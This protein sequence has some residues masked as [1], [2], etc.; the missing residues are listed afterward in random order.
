MLGTEDREKAMNNQL[1]VDTRKQHTKESPSW[2]GHRSQSKGG[3]GNL[4]CGNLEQ[5]QRKNNKARD[6]FWRLRRITFLSSVGILLLQRHYL[7]VSSI[8]CWMLYSCSFSLSLIFHLC[9]GEFWELLLLRVSPPFTG[10]LPAS[11]L[12]DNLL[13]FSLSVSPA[14]DAWSFFGRF[15]SMAFLQLVLRLIVASMENGLSHCLH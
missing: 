3:V 14:D 1:S 11:T 13:L 8:Y 5:G 6:K 4:V 7:R 10:L 9:R 2:K 15:E 12:C